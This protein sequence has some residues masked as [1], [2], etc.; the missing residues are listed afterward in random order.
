[1]TDL[2]HVTNR[3]DKALTFVYAFKS[4]ELPVGKSVQIPLKA[5]KEVFGHGDVNKEPY[6]AHLGWIRLHSDLEQGME[7][8]A[9]FIISDEPLIEENR[10]LPSAVGVVPLHVEKRA[11]GST[12]QRVA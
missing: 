9:Q 3:S 5:A 1:M 2:V 8:L 11:G 6:L 10:S 12:R 4:Y 7:R